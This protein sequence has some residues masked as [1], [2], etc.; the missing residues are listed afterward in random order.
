MIAPEGTEILQAELF[1]MMGRPITVIY[2]GYVQSGIMKTVSFSVK[3]LPSGM[4]TLVVGTKDGMKKTA[5]MFS[6]GH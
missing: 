6:I 1:D 4:Y 3:D 2:D 5:R